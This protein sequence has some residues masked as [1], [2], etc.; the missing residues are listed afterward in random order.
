MYLPMNY[1][2]IN[3]STGT[4]TPAT[5]KNRNNKSF[6][7]W[8]RALFQRAQSVLKFDFPEEVNGRYKDFVIYCL[9]KY[10]FVMV[11]YDASFGTFLQ[12][13]TLGGC[14]FYY[15]PEYANLN[16][17]KLSKKYKIGTECGILKL[18]PDFMGV[19]D[20]IDYYAEKL[21]LLDNSINVSLVNSK[22]PYILGAKNKSTA[23]ALKK[24]LDLTNQGEPAIVFNQRIQ[25]DA[26]SEDTP[27]QF[28]DLNVKDRFMLTEQLEDFANI[29]RSFDCEIGIPTLPYEKKE[30]IISD[31]AN[32]K[33]NEAIARLTVWVNSLKA[34]ILDIKEVFPDITLEVEI[35]FEK[36]GG[37]SNDSEDDADR[38]LPVHE[39]TT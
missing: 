7:F 15:Q 27:F 11:G 25:D 29:L 19:W 2:K 34:S 32:S 21:S 37:A 35:N 36:L 30:R 39:R 8:E 38:S 14:D 20:I 26:N 13:C 16:N 18:T 12:P 9:F 24:I 33:S 23:Q 3:L 28:L 31:E 6:A 17:P 22:Y 5:M 10:G 4:Y 1:E